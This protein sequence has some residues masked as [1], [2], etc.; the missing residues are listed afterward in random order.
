MDKIMI[1]RE[2]T[3]RDVKRL[4]LLV[5][6]KYRNGIINEVEAQKEAYILNSLLKV[7]EITDLEQRLQNI[8]NIL[9]NE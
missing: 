4:L 1:E 6:K 5:Y 2:M 8:E 7:I 3:A 9:K